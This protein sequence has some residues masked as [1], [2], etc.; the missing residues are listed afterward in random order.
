MSDNYTRDSRSDLSGMSKE[1]ALQ[2]LK[3][4]YQTDE[5]LSVENVKLAF[6][7]WLLV[8]V[9]VGSVVGFVWSVAALL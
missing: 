3:P 8:L 5:D 2:Y 7:P 9:I 1:A 6:G 4:H